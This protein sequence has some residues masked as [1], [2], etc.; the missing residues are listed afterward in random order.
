MT[1]NMLGGE[2]TRDTIKK[3]Y[4]SDFYRIIGKKGGRLSR[5]GGFASTKVSLDGLTGRQR[6]VKVGAI[7]G[8]RSKRGPAKKKQ[9]ETTDE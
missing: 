3:K 7:G 2:K 8:T 4:G 6:A 9:G 5:N 1:G